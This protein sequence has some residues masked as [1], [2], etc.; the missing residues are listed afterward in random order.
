LLAAVGL[1]GVLAYTVR[2]R[3]REIGIRAALGAQRADVI[4]LVLRQGM[5]L[6]GI[7][8]LIGLAGAFALTQLI[9][10]LLFG[11]APTDPLT[12]A[13]I[14]LLLAAVA[15]LACWVP[16]RRAANVDP[17]EALRYE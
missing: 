3:A 17:M 15:L 13:T 11:V 16:A 10:K 8:M 5:T 2:Q 12:F 4:G 7:G 1:Y 14:P 6:T 9:R